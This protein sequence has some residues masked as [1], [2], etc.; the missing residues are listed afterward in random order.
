MCTHLFKRGS[1]YY[2]RRRIPTDL[3]GHYKRNEIQQALGTSDPAEA[4]VRCRRI[5]AQLDEEFARVRAESADT[6]PPQ[7]MTAAEVEA[8]ERW[9]QHN[10]EAAAHFA[11]NAECEAEEF[12]MLKRAIRAVLSETGALPYAA[13]SAAHAGGPAPA[14]DAPQ[15]GMPLSRLTE[16]WADERKPDVRTVK[17]M[18]RVTGRFEALVG[19]V[20]VHRITRRH[21]V[22]FKDELLAS[23][24]SPVNTD[25]Q[26]V[27]F[28][29]L[30]NYAVSNL[31]LD[32]NPAKGVRVGER[33]NA[34]AARL[35]F[36]L[37]ALH[38]IFGSPV[39]SRGARPDGGAGEAAYWLPLLALFTG[40]RL[41]ELAQLRPEDVY[42]E[43]YRDEHDAEAECWVLRITNEGESQGVKNAGSV[44]R[45]PVHPE[46]LARGF[47]E[48]I[49]VQ[50]G[51]TRVFP[52]QPDAF[53]AEAGNW[54]KWFGKYLRRVCKVTDKRMV[55][56]S[57]RHLFKDLCREAGITDEVSDAL[58][59]HSSSKVSRR[60]GGLTYPLRPL[61]DA[62]RRY[63]VPGLVLP[64]HPRMTDAPL[65]HHTMQPERLADR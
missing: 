57:F 40:A 22:K 21:V 59:G 8:W 37:K 32:H 47:I 64:A 5:G 51:K 29:T 12:E 42:R 55:F 1:R 61:V 16:K 35:P 28:G 13:T 23:G 54:G 53:G 17:I 7:R 9:Q 44:R 36:D 26:L 31:L 19:K 39:Y 11:Y 38:A 3:V 41:E 6:P 27:N 30:L 43:T 50:R 49:Q 10:D 60:Y 63:R 65:A 33:K 14:A 20:P 25:K 56:H 18:E 48:F 34:K 2:I 52:L 58:S 4:R 62:V 46:I 45:F 24:Q 15:G